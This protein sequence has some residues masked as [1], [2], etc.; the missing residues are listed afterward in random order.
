MPP[1]NFFVWFFL[2][3]GF[4]FPIADVCLKTIGHNTTEHCGYS[5]R[6]FDNCGCHRAN[7]WKMIKLQAVLFP[8]PAACNIQTSAMN[9]RC[10][11]CLV[12]HGS[13][14]RCG[15]GKMAYACRNCALVCI[16]RAIQK[17]RVLRTRKLHVIVVYIFLHR[18]SEPCQAPPSLRLRRWCQ[19]LSTAE[20][21]A[22]SRMT[23]NEWAMSS[24]HV[25]VYGHKALR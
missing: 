23:H 8:F 12:R 6:Y 5:Y 21:E 1:N 2:Y 22:C 14:P 15:M 13:H 16:Y 4:S 20:L 10:L 3:S 25:Y 24:L 18:T 19:V 17:E 7:F 11:Q 9:C